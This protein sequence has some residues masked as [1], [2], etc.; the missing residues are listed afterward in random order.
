MFFL[1]PRTLLCYHQCFGG[2]TIPATTWQKKCAQIQKQ[3]GI[4]WH[5]A[6]PS[7]LVTNQSG[8]TWLKIQLGSIPKTMQNQT[9]MCKKIA[10][11]LDV[12]TC[13]QKSATTPPINQNTW[14]TTIANRLAPNRLND[15]PKYQCHTDPNT[16][17]EQAKI[18]LPLPRPA[19]TYR[20]CAIILR[21]GCRQ[22]NPKSPTCWMILNLI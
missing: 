13:A 4:L 6:V 9:R 11:I 15:G 7:T 19:A 8:W 16:T 10:W 21:C 2:S 14:T 5:I 18:I 17:W 12:S 1:H 3:V 22:C 20:S